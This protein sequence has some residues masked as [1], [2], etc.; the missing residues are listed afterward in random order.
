MSAG[1]S[2]ERAKMQGYEESRQT[3]VVESGQEALVIHGPGVRYTGHVANELL[4]GM[5]MSKAAKVGGV[6]RGSQLPTR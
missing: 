3:E 6:R 5:H 4:L 2:R 1:A